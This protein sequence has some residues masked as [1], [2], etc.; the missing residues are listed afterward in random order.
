L[1]PDTLKVMKC[2]YKGIL[3]TILAVLFVQCEEESPQYVN[4]PDDAFLKALIEEGVDVNNDSL[5]SFTEAAAIATLDVSGFI[6]GSGY[7][8]RGISSLKGIEAFIHLDTLDC[9]INNIRELDLSNQ[10][11][12]RKLE[13]SMN[14]LTGLDI[15]MCADITYLDCSV[16]YDLENLDVSS[17]TALQYL[18]CQWHNMETLDVS[19]NIALAE[20][21]CSGSRLHSLDLSENT[22][23]LTLNCGDSPIGKLDISHNTRLMHLAIQYCPHLFEVC[24]PSLPFPPPGGSVSMVQSPNVYFTTECSK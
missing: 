13:C 3:L 2:L 12:L 19:G 14:L 7:N 4:I 22:E 18:N 11:A 21:A 10:P 17:N 15:S 5:I 20:L 9:S 16:N 24:V 8:K 1:K 23:L 6:Y